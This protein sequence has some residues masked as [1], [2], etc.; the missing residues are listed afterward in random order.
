MVAQAAAAMVNRPSQVH[1]SLGPVGV[2]GTI[3]GLLAIGLVLVLVRFLLQFVICIVPAQIAADMMVRIRSQVLSAFIRASWAEQ[4]RDREGLLQEL[5]T[6]QSGAAVQCVLLAATL[7]V[8]AITFVILV[9]AAVTLNAFTALILVVTST[10]LFAVLRPVNNLGRRFAKAQSATSVDWAGGVNESVRLAE[11]THVFG[12]G[13]AQGQ[14][15]DRLLEVLR[16]P[17]YQVQ[18]LTRLTPSVYQ[19]LVYLLV[20][21][22]LIALYAIGG[23]HAAALGAVVLLL[24]RAG[25][26]GQQVQTAYQGLLVSL[27][28]LDRVREAE[29]RYEDSRDAAGSLRLQAVRSVALHHVGYEYELARPVLRDITFEVMAGEA[30]GIV[31]PSGAGKSTLVQIL[32]G[33]RSPSEGQYLVNGERAAEFKRTDWHGRIA[34][35][36]QEPRLLHASVADNIRFFRELDDA[37]VERAAVSAGIHD[38]IV[39]WPLGYNTVV[40]P[41]ADAVSG[42]Q[43]QRICLARALADNPEILVLDE[44]TS[45]LDPHTEIRIQESLV[46]IK[47]RLTLFVVAHRMSTLDICDRMMVIVDGRLQAF[48]AV[49]D[50]RSS[51]AYYRSVTDIGVLA[52]SKG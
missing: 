20:V 34:Y 51:S 30:V 12:T 42:G 4:S 41:R 14:R 33:L 32:L 26:Y 19:S 11:E 36:P 5:L 6:N 43:Q 45:A 8:T 1:I 22:A 25:M 16:G 48:G 13:A 46:A 23:G 18:L 27:P 15:A 52:A 49:A 37:A 28:F 24:V 50:L 10:G 44:P 35:V 38:D 40:G 29:L 9:L 31:G 47:N 3:G 21:L 17:F 2:T 39:T 7:V